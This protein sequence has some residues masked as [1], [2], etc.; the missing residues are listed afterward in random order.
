M[1]KYDDFGELRAFHRDYLLNAVVP[2]WMAHAIDREHG[3]LFTCIRD[4]G[5]IVNT[6]KYPWSQLRATG[7]FSALYTMIFS[8]AFDELGDVLKVHDWS[9]EHYPDEEHGEWTQRLTR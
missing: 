8:C 4:D 1:T 7:T 3:G 9:W 2:F 5:T 6:D